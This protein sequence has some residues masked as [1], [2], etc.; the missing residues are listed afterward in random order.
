LGLRLLSSEGKVDADTLIGDGGCLGGVGT[1]RTFL[2]FGGQADRTSIENRSGMFETGNTIN[3]FVGIIEMLITDMI[4]ALMPE[5]SFSI[6]MKP[7]DLKVWSS[8]DPINVGE[9]FMKHSVRGRSWVRAW[10][11]GT[12]KNDRCGVE[13]STGDNA[14]KEEIV[15]GTQGIEG[16]EGEGTSRV[17]R[18]SP[19]GG[20]ILRDKTEERGRREDSGRNLRG[21]IHD[22]LMIALGSTGG[23]KTTVAIANGATALTIGSNKADGTRLVGWEFSIAMQVMAMISSRGLRSDIVVSTRSIIVKLVELFK[24]GNGSRDGGRISGEASQ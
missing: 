13:K 1:R 20:L 14:M 3:I 9:E 10:T 18:E 22:G 21:V 23:R 7:L 8:G 12:G 24:L 5:K 11:G 16:F 17:G 2:E 6:G 4:E 15:T 19:S